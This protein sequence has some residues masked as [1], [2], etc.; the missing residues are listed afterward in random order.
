MIR[1]KGGSSMEIRLDKENIV[2][3]GMTHEE[4]D[5]GK[6]QFPTPF[7]VDGKAVVSVFVDDDT[8]IN[9]AKPCRWFETADKGAHWNEVSP[10]IQEKCGLELP[11]GDKLFFPTL[12][13]TDLS[14]YTFT[15]PT[16]LTPDY[17]FSKPAEGKQ[18]P[19]QDGITAWFTGPVI[20]AY[21]ADRLPY[22]LCEK[23]WTV[24][25]VTGKEKVTEYAPLDWPYLTRV[26]MEHKGKNFMKSIQPIRKPKLAPDGSIWVSAFSGEGH[27]NPKNGQYSPYYS[28]EIL[29]STDNG[30]T[31]QLHAHM[32]YPAD[33]EEYPYLSG[34][35]SDN[36]FA[37][38]DDG[39]I[40]WFFRSTW[41]G[42]TG[43]EWAPMYHSRSVDGGKTWDKPK[44]FSPMGVFPSLCKL[45]C[46]MTLICYAR[47]GLFV[48][49]CKNDDPTHWT[50][51]IE[52]LPAENRSGLS[53]LQPAEP[54]WHQWDGQCGNP[55]LI[56]VSDNEALLLYGDFYYPDEH[57]IKRKTILSR[58]ITVISG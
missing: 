54:T 23:K 25:R 57:G 6:Y 58:K 27:I 14:D 31:F 36:D 49:A 17:D 20:R 40:I 22:P 18:L 16:M 29:R 35:F 38:M 50:D 51:P 43:W 26:V 13:G 2:V 55:Q 12:P 45:N 4:N 42:S 30:K 19:I 32:E 8:L 11:N 48:R 46:G 44:V 34:G 7:F 10:D 47:P 15:H 3:Q 53:N 56:A 24:E 9:D 37:F 28:A 33:G 5:W 39:S 21:N 52:V 41:Y 1:K